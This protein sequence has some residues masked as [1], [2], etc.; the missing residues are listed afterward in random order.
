MIPSLKN[1]TSGLGLAGLFA[2]MLAGAMPAAALS[3]VVLDYREI[4]PYDPGGELWEAA[5]RPGIFATNLTV[6]ADRVLRS[7]TIEMAKSPNARGGFRLDLFRVTESR[8]AT[9]L[10]YVTPL[11]GSA[12]P[13]NAGAYTYE[14]P[15]GMA[16]S[17]RYILVATVAEGGGTYRWV[18]RNEPGAQSQR[19]ILYGLLREASAS[20]GSS[21][22]S[23][24]LD[25]S[26][27][28]SGSSA[29][30]AF[31]NSSSVTIGAPQLSSDHFIAL[32]LDP[33]KVVLTRSNPGTASTTENTTTNTVLGTTN[34]TITPIEKLI[35]ADN[36]ASLDLPGSTLTIQSAG[37]ITQT[38]N[39]PVTVTP[40][41]GPASP[42][43]P[44][45]M[46][47]L[48][49]NS[50]T[51]S[52]ES[53]TIVTASS[54]L[55]ATEEGYV[56]PV[57]VSRLTLHADPDHGASFAVSLETSD[58]ASL[59]G[60]DRPAPFTPVAVGASGRTRRI[61]VRNLADLP[62]SRLTVVANA[63]TKRHFLITQPSRSVIA[64]G[65]IT[66]FL[67]TPTPK[68]AGLLKGR[69]EVRSSV[70]KET[71]AVSVRATGSSRLR[72]KAR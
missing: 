38:I 21:V 30:L 54:F 26:N 49:M 14:V 56:S 69:I 46:G 40:G 51:L 63:E 13:A 41:S 5:G 6:P 31:A 1:P 39:V 33:A 55:S 60:V 36:L 48:S 59:L 28:Y 47:S 67:V 23:G 65:E 32:G 9:N 42:G 64:P 52:G 16:L 61:V 50:L 66:E 43:S 72:S 3:P 7:V 71:I 15:A 22:S 25:L 70:G 11:T 4:A 62:L 12:N 19:R 68:K 18:T 2:W 57:E 37:P 29:V 27:S 44:L 58:D 20:T 8:T 45:S 35:I 34:G 10:A 17:G 24:S 53:P